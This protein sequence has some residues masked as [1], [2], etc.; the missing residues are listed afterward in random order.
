MQSGWPLL[1]I[2]RCVWQIDKHISGETVRAA[3]FCGRGQICLWLHLDSYKR[4]SRLHWA[5][6][7]TIRR[8][9]SV[10]HSTRFLYAVMW[11]HKCAKWGLG[12]GARTSATGGD[13]PA[14]GHST[15]LC[16]TQ[17]EPDSVCPLPF[18]R[19][20]A[21]KLRPATVAEWW[22]A[23]LWQAGR[24]LARGRA[25]MCVWIWYFCFLA[26]NV[27]AVWSFC[28]FPAL[29]AI[30]VL[31]IGWHVPTKICFTVS[32]WQAGRVFILGNLGHEGDQS[33]LQVFDTFWKTWLWERLCSVRKRKVIFSQWIL[34]FW[35]VS[36]ICLPRWAPHVLPLMGDQDKSTL[37]FRL[38]LF[39]FTLEILFSALQPAVIPSSSECHSACS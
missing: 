26:F 32:Y 39:L 22:A 4:A 14:G 3:L 36:V 10:S 30:G 33:L 29:S 37:I 6:S 21:G 27:T 25:G 8:N 24:G 7:E 28:L 17:A 16:H 12:A 9:C 15:L 31:A 11:H 23:L 35:S 1:C 34:L 2:I 38:C 19:R 18:V 20:A 13:R 5:P